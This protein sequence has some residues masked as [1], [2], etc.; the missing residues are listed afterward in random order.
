MASIIVVF[1][2]LEDS[3][4]IRGLLVRNGFEVATPCIA[5]AQAIAIADGL[6]S[7]IIVSGYKLKDML[8]SEIYEYKPKSFDLL[9]VASQSRLAECDCR[10]IQSVS[11]PIKPNDLIHTLRTMTEAQI[12]RRRQLQKRPPRRSPEEQRVVDRA[13]ALLMEKDGMTEEA[14]YR[15]IQKCSMDS[16]NRFVESAYM[17]ISMYG[18]SARDERK[19]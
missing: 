12:A 2:R 5:G 11:M 13:K 1:P 18:N 9:L 15:Y 19:R 7:G 14:A 8:Y 17:I 10:H 6:S 4:M 3:R 16:G